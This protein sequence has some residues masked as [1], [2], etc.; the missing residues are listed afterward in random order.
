MTVLHRILGRTLAG[1]GLLACLAA[2]AHAAGFPDRPIS[3]IVPYTPGEAP[4][5]WR[6]CSASN[7]PWN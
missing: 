3:I 2:P 1:A 7:W 6:A 4:T 5:S